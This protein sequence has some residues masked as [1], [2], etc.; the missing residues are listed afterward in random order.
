M[1]DR[2]RREIFPPNFHL[3]KK[4]GRSELDDC[5]IK[6]VDC[7]RSMLPPIFGSRLLSALVR[8]F[9]R[10]LCNDL[11]VQPLLHS[12]P[13]ASVSLSILILEASY[14]LLGFETD[15]I[16]SYLTSTKLCFM[17]VPSSMS[18]TSFRTMQCHCIA[19]PL[20]ITAAIHE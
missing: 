12:Y 20:C 15:G 10:G 4:R 5:N 13:V 3:I 1:T 7:Y 9:S 17:V 11:K 16:V 14:R 8:S 19:L 6:V 2:P 18:M